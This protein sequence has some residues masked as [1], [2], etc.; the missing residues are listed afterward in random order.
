MRA[1]TSAWIDP[2]RLDC[3]ASPALRRSCRRKS[4]LPSARST[5]LATTAAGIDDA[6]V[7]SRRASSA[8][9]GARSMPISGAPWSTVRQAAGRR[10]AGEARRHHQQQGLPG[11]E[12]GE[13]G[14][15]LERPGVGPVDVLDHQEQRRGRSRPSSPART[16]RAA[17][18]ARGPRC[19]SPRR[20]RAARAAASRRAG[21]RGTAGGRGRS[22]GP[23]RRARSLPDARP[24]RPCRRRPAG[25]APGCGSRPGRSPRRSRARRRR[26][27]KSRASRP[28]PRTRRRAATCRR[29]GS[30]RTTTTRLRCRSA[31]AAATA[32]KSRSSSSRPTSGPA[33]AAGA[34]RSPRMR[35]GES[36]RSLPLTS[37]GAPASAS[38][39]SATC[40][41]VSALTSTSPGRAR[42]RRRAAVFTAS[43]VSA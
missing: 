1:W 3:A 22:A 24:A 5:Q 28:G 16:R 12:Q 20:A 36:G 30:P 6:W 41:Q 19:S 27:R 43:P 38:K 29:P 14:Q 8:F 17:T 40:C 39:W 11:G 9:K 35:Y 26:G 21:R 33:P 18:P 7:A 10:V 4:G 15:A 13:R 34:A 42:L 25:C 31:Q 23:R 32:A 2:G 37:T